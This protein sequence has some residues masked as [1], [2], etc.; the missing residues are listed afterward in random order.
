[1]SHAANDSMSDF[2]AGRTCLVTGGA[3][4]IGSHL[5]RRLVGAGARPIVFDVVPKSERSL[6]AAFDLAQHVEYVQGDVRS[7]EDLKALAGRP[8]DFVFHLAAQPIS[9]LSNLQPHET[10][11]V[12]AGGTREL[13]AMLSDSGSPTVVLASS[14]CAYGIPAMGASPLKE[15]DL[16]RKGFYAYTESKQKAEQ[17][18]F[19]AKG[20]RGVIGRF[21]NVYG[22]GDR[23]FSRI[24]PKTIR[25]LLRDLPLALSRGDGSTVL[26]FLYVDEA[27]DGF[28]RLAN[29]TAK[30]KESVPQIFNF[31]IGSGNAVSMGDLVSRISVVYD[32]RS[33]VLETK[34]PTTEPPTE[35]FLDSTKAQTLLNWR[36]KVLL[37]SGLR[38][39]IDWYRNHLDDL[40]H[41]EDTYYPSLTSTPKLVERAVEKD[42]P[43]D[44]PVVSA[45]GQS[46][47]ASAY[48]AAAGANSTDAAVQDVR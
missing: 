25:L 44:R 5:C 40:A 18:L 43:A 1:M 36:P 16:L 30:E 34:T 23:H 45:P 14:A 35:K 27:I 32:G 2:L 13:C 29:Y 42:F 33:R 37:E 20:I 46:Q 47:S 21:V 7:K 41:L 15:T 39:T 9:G 4:F 38:K 8:F 22:P 10:I 19:A 26:D 12:N 28:L 6:F 24:I 17:E 11:R 48:R 3:G 31:G